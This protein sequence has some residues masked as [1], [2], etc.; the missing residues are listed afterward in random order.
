MQIIDNLSNKT[1][2]G[3]DDLSYQLIKRIKTSLTKP[4]S[5]IMI[6]ILNS[7]IFPEK[8]KIAKVIPI[9]KKDDNKLFNNYRPISLLPV[10]SKIVEKCM[11]ISS[12]TIISSRT[13]IMFCANQYGFR[14]GHCTEYAALEIIDR[15]T[16]QLDNKDI[17]LNIFL[18]LSKAFDS[19]D[20]VILLNK[21]K[22][23]GVK[24]NGVL[25]RNASTAYQKLLNR[26]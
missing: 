17:P 5:K 4:L 20:H 9:Y 8:L 24:C 6:Q 7:G 12:F 10:I 2:R 18:D 22:Y 14:T 3:N 16:T 19:L 13:I 25:Q 1:S 21:L 26:S 15:V 23:Y 11:Y